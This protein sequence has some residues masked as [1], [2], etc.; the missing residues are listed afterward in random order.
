MAR[1][2]AI[3]AAAGESTRMGR[4]KPLLPWRGMTLVEYQIASL[5]EGGVEEVM[6]V[7]GHSAGD[8]EP[9][10][11]DPRA[12]SVLNPA[13]RRGKATSI[14]TGLRDIGRAADGILLL[15]VDQPRPAE[16]IAMVLSAHEKGDALITAPRYQGRGGHPPVFAAALRPE[17]EAIT[18]E[19][20]G[21]RR[22]FRAHRD[23]VN[24]V[25]IDDPIVC[26]DLNTPEDYEAARAKYGA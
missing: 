21:I 4:A 9:Y 13:Y 23:E 11:K 3:L 8:V 1:I 24:E 7:L 12:R 6:V 18:E 5:I 2:S 10:V 15:A 22:V 17:L 25:A 14:V 16:I 20:E 26:L 19:A